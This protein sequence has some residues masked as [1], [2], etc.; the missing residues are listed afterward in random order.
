MENDLNLTQHI[1]KR[2]NQ[3]LED[4]RSSVLEMGGMVELQLKNGVKALRKTNP[5][6]AESVITSDYEINAKEV[7][8]DER[9]TQIVARRQPAASDLRLVMAIIKTITD[10]E[11]IGDEAEALGRYAMQLAEEQSKSRDFVEIKHLGKHVRT[12][13]R[14]A[15]DA[16]ARLDVEAALETIT[17]GS[18]VDVEFEAINRQLITKMMEDPRE[19]RNALRVSWAARSLE[20]TGD[21]AK[22]ICEYVVY[23][24]KGKNVRHTSLDSVIDE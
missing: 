13:L 1:S 3:E 17:S 15:L 8:I 14:N 10:L 20:R 5:E 7:E 18:E 23:L 16:F 21:H 19:V 12:M 6:L 24:V 9:C 4:L 22:N 2:Y 11:R